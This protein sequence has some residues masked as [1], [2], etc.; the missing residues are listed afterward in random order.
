VTLGKGMFF[1][2][3]H[4]EH[5]AK[6]PSPLPSAVT[7]TFLY[8]VLTDTRQSTIKSTRQRSR[9]RCTVRRALFTECHTRQR[10][11]RVFFRLCLVLQA[12]GK[13]LDSG[14]VNALIFRT[15]TLR[16]SKP[17]LCLMDYT[18]YNTNKQQ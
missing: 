17:I 10:L 16:I 12:L 4:L 8:R 9:C 1:A 7:A 13:A 18:L 14:S 5:S 15:I 11:C 6:T 3:C 2:E